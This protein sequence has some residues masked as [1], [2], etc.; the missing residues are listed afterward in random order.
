MRQGDKAAEVGKGMGIFSFSRSRVNPLRKEMEGLKTEADWT[1]LRDTLGKSKLLY[2]T[3]G[4]EDAGYP[5]SQKVWALFNEHKVAVV[6]E[7]R[8]GDHEWA[9]WR[10][11]LRDF[12]QKAFQ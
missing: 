8:P 4:T 11:G 7:P 10:P 3:V 9:V 12:A 5:D 6:T 2:W 1:A